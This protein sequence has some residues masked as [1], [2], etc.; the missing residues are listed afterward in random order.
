MLEPTFRPV[1]PIHELHR[2][3]STAGPRRRRRGFPRAP[4]SVH[5]AIKTALTSCGAGRPG[6]FPRS[7]TGVGPGRTG[8]LLAGPRVPGPVILLAAHKG[9]EEIPPPERMEPLCR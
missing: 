7:E 8:G 5:L 2:S 4:L 9:P 1:H 6:V 3:R